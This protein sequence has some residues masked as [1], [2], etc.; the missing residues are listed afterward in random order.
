MVDLTVDDEIST[1]PGEQD[2]IFPTGYINSHRFPSAVPGGGTG[3]QVAGMFS[4]ED[5]NRAIAVYYYAIA[6]R[7]GGG[8]IMGRKPPV[9]KEQGCP[10]YASLGVAQGLAHQAPIDGDTEHTQN[11]MLD[12]DKG[13]RLERERMRKRQEA[14]PS[15]HRDVTGAEAGDLMGLILEQL[16]APNPSKAIAGHLAKSGT[17]DMPELSPCS[18]FLIRLSQEE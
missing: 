11:V 4:L 15:A 14:D 16:C 1:T 17:V 18:C 8:N 3:T 7:T 5:L 13:A 12:F 6:R 2:I 10:G 9:K